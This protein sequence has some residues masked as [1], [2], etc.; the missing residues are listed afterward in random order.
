MTR[1]QLEARRTPDRSRFLPRERRLIDRLSTPPRVQD[2]LRD[3]PYNDESRGRSLRTF[4]GVV[5]HG[6]A[7]CLEAVFA[8]ATILE[9]QGDPP[10]VLDLASQDGL[11]H[12]LLLYRRQGRW[13]S[14]GRSRDPG[15]HGRRPVFRRVRDLAYSYVDP[16]IDGSGRILAY[17]V[18]DLDALTRADWRLSDR[19][20]WSVERA[21]MDAPHVPL[22]TS[23]RRYERMLCRYRA[24][25]ARDPDAPATDYAGKDRW[26]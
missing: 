14:I 20:V 26:L 8:A 23:D 17:G 5:R 11:D 24:F 15:L 19:H 9:R 22:A 18:Y 12:V 16:Y 6:E 4:R 3:L 7:H 2:W 1:E 10:L 21:L 25:R 13:G